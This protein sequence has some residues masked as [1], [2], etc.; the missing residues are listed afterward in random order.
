MYALTWTQISPFTVINAL[1][2]INVQHMAF[3][4]VNSRIH[5]K[6]VILVCNQHITKRKTVIYALNQ[7][8]FWDKYRLRMYFI[9]TQRNQPSTCA[10]PPNKNKSIPLF[11]QFQDNMAILS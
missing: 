4:L 8:L 11:F 10:G 9:N 3:F 1:K 5:T 7:I 6:I 2:D